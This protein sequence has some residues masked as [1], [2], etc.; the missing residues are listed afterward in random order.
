MTDKYAQNGWGG[1]PLVMCID[2]P[3]EGAW[4]T[5]KFWQQAR[6]SAIFNGETPHTGRTLGYVKTGKTAPNRN[7]PEVRGHILAWSPDT[8]AA[9]MA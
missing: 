5:L 6:T 7:N 2:G 9:A 1:E 8:A 3:R 4:Y